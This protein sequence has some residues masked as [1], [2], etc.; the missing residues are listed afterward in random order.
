MT[1]WLLFQQL[2]EEGPSLNLYLLCARSKSA[3]C[4]LR[5]TQSLRIR[6]ILGPAAPAQLG[7]VLERTWTQPLASGWGLVQKESVLNFVLAGR[8][9]HF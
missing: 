9:L 3:G 8:F 1:I 7:E 5:L 6:Y 2:L 4:P